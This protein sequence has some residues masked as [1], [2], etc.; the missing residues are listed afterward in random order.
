MAAISYSGSTL[1]NLLKRHS[2]VDFLFFFQSFCVISDSVINTLQH[3]F[4]IFFIH[5]FPKVEA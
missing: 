5:R 2:F 4:W 1:A 3:T